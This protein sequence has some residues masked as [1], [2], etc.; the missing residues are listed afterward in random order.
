MSIN[1]SNNATLFFIHVHTIL[2][3]TFNRIA[4]NAFLQRRAKYRENSKQLY[5]MVKVGRTRGNAVPGPLKVAGERSQAPPI[6]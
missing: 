5:S 2:K 6:H 1:Q 4:V 3:F